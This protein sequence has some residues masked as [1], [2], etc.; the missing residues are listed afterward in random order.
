MRKEENSAGGKRVV[1]SNGRAAELYWKVH[2]R[3][4]EEKA[5]SGDAY[6]EQREAGTTRKRE[7]Q[8]RESLVGGRE[9]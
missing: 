4:G 5:G 3:D 2:S 6:L 9:R 8:L 7:G 1:F